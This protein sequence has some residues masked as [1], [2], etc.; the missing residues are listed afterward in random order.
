MQ[1]ARFAL[2][3]GRGGL[4]AKLIR[5]CGRIIEQAGVADAFEMS[6]YV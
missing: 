3:S 1:F 5:D 4:I 6:R 2:I